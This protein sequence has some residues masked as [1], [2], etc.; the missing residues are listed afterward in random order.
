MF[1]QK[2]TKSGIIKQLFI[3]SF[4]I[5]FSGNVH[6]AQTPKVQPILT[7]VQA[8]AEDSVYTFAEKMPEFPGGEKALIEFLRKTIVFPDE[9]MKNNEHGKVYVQ[10]VVRKTGKAADAKI[11][12]SVSTSLDNEALR[13]IGLLPDWTPGEQNGE[14]VSVTRVIP[15]SFQPAAPKDTVAEWQPNEKTVVLIDGVKMPESFN[16][17]IINLGKMATAT[18]LKPF[19]DK[20][21]STLMK[22]YGKQAADGVILLT[23]KKEG[24][25]YLLA[26]STANTA[27]C[28][29]A[30]VMPSFP[31]GEASLTAYIADSIQYP[32]V[33]KRLNTQGKVIVQ[34]LIDKTGKIND[35]KVIRGT[36]YFLDKEALRLI[37][38]MPNWIPAT[39]CNEKVNAY[40]SLPVVFKL[41]VP[42]KEKTWERDAKTIILLNGERLPATFN[43]DWLNYAGLTGYQVLQPTTKEVTKKLTSQYGKDAAHGV[44][45]ISTTSNKK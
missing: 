32:F 2:S 29:D 26:D 40:V 37:G 6:A 23:S 15:I 42:A 41:D 14:K 36:D 12:R 20:E 22:K 17:G 21:K 43:L 45:L 13:V 5:C 9:A 19:P 34:F 7:N 44:I 11:I 16:I 8:V 30:A 24:I 18:V 31:G 27:A 1:L 10:F 39:K 4:A 25:Q 35:A 33:A 3:A 38:T 28:K